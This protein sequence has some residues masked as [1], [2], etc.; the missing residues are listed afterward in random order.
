MLLAMHLQQAVL[1]VAAVQP[2]LAVLVVLE[3][4]ELLAWAAARD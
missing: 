1:V 4:L 3:L 2:E